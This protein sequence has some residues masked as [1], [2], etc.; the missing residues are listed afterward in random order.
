MRDQDDNTGFAA[1]VLTSA[2]RAW[3]VASEDELELI[4]PPITEL[5]ARSRDCGAEC[6]AAIL[7]NPR[8]IH[9]GKLHCKLNVLHTQ[10][11]RCETRPNT[12]LQAEQFPHR[13]LQRVCHQSSTV[14]PIQGNKL[15][16]SCIVMCLYLMT[17]LFELQQ[18]WSMASLPN[19][20]RGLM[21]GYGGDA[22]HFCP[23]L[24]S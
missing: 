17:L 9:N 20:V 6:S 3:P 4:K 19:R 21:H 2:F 7:R 8:D 12:S 24:Q 1:C 5:H 14:V 18:Q 22:V 16:T 11:S 23:E 13:P 15:I 10:S